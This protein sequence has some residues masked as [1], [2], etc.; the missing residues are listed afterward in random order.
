MREKLPRTNEF[1]WHCWCIVITAAWSA[2]RDC[3]K[4][5]PACCIFV[6]TA[7]Y[8]T[9]CKIRKWS[10]VTFENEPPPPLADCTR[11]AVGKNFLR[12][13]MRYLM[14]TTPQTGRES[15]R[16]ESLFEVNERNRK[17]KS[18]CSSK[19]IRHGGLRLVR[20]VLQSKLAQ[21]TL[22]SSRHV[23]GR[24]NFALVPPNMFGCIPHVYHTRESTVRMY[25]METP[26]ELSKWTKNKKRYRMSVH[27][28]GAHENN[29]MEAC[30]TGPQVLFTSCTCADKS[31]CDYFDSFQ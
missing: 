17:S 13:F 19:A 23:L 4:G 10:R 12:E 15:S 7:R 11:I 14:Q 18:R 22:H 5:Y 20:F 25:A 3:M 30:E 16:S 26:R 28:T 21:F 9:L 8:A 24:V 31:T 6:S 1:P 29:K 27:G 2:C